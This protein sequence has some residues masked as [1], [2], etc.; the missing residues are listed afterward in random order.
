MTRTLYL[1]A[2]LLIS[3]I[4]NVVFL[5]Q[6][7][8]EEPECKLELSQGNLAAV[9]GARAEEQKSG[10]VSSQISKA[11]DHKATVASDNAAASTNTSKETIR[12]VYR[13]TPA[14]PVSCRTDRPL[15]D[16]VQ[17]AIDG[18]VRQANTPEG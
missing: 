18:A 1:I 10:Q 7:A 3:L 4:L 16:G 11:T 6:W 2:A 13:T 17:S 9:N 5:W 14:K 12:Y 8:Q 15:H